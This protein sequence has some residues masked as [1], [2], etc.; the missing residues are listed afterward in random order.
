VKIF[1][2]HLYRYELPLLTPFPRSVTRVAKGH[3]FVLRSEQG[4]RYAEVADAALIGDETPEL[5]E[6]QLREILSGKMA[7]ENA[8]APIRWALSS[9]LSEFA[10]GGP[11]ALNAL[12]DASGSD[13]VDQ[14]LSRHTEGYR[15]FKIKIG[16]GHLNE[17]I[18]RIVELTKVLGKGISLR[19]DA[20]RKLN[21]GAAVEFAKALKKASIEYFEEPFAQLDLTEEF[22]KLTGCKVALDETVLTADFASWKEHEAVGAYVLKPSRIGSL[23]EVLQLI[24]EAKLAGRDFVVS[25]TFESSIGL[26]ALAKVAS[27]GQ[28][29]PVAMGL[30]TG[31]Y[32]AADLISPPLRPF[33]GQ[34]VL[35]AFHDAK[36]NPS[37]FECAASK[38]VRK[39]E[40]EGAPL[41]CS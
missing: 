13:L 29:R 25:S 40:F 16:D 36:E 35:G 28:S 18:S 24:D 26:L 39:L 4:V 33:R 2:S 23:P 12:L 19:L 30:A 15:C 32:F 31:C 37:A 17:E 9:A 7:I 21:L 27:L 20:N 41:S 11:I 3:L 6:A 8:C 34:I 1:G 10:P 38:W 5:V 22:F 14:G